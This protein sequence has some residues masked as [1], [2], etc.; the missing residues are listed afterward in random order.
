MLLKAS[1][2]GKKSKQ[3]FEV[4]PGNQTRNLRTEGRPLTAQ[5]VSVRPSVREVPSSIPVTSYRCFEFSPVSVALTSINTL[6]MEHWWREGG[7][8]S[9]LSTSSLSVESLS[10]VINVKCGCFTYLP[11]NQ[12][13]QFL[14]VDHMHVNRIIH[15]LSPFEQW[16]I[17]LPLHLCQYNQTPPD[18]LLIHLSVCSTEQREWWLPVY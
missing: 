15:Y 10:R 14:H 12:L 6:K 16:L 13:H 4:T 17:N 8:M 7:K 5:L 1:R 11:F 3:G 9:A 2:K 18:H